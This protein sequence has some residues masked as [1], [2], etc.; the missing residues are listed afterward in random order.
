MYIYS[1]CMY[2]HI[3]GDIVYMHVHV[4]VHCTLTIILPGQSPNIQVIN[5]NDRRGRSQCPAQG[6]GGGRGP[7]EGGEEGE[8]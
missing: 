5:L 8:S 4:H 1:T 6:C 7:R 3:D 2:I